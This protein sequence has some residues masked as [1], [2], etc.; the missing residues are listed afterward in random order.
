MTRQQALISCII[1]PPGWPKYRRSYSFQPEQVSRRSARRAWENYLSDG[2]GV[3]SFR[4]IIPYSIALDFLEEFPRTFK[5]LD[6][7]LACYGG[8]PEK[9]H[10]AGVSNGGLAA[11][12]L[13]LERSDHEP[14]SGPLCVLPCGLSGRPR[15]RAAVGH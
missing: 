6:E 5:I 8:D 14:G 4:I 9:V 13:M 11:F 3:E 15:G 10:I 1:P 7:V 2:R 12:A